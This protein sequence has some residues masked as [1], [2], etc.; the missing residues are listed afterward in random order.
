MTL[1]QRPFPQPYAILLFSFSA[2]FT[3]ALGLWLAQT[4]AAEYREAKEPT[5][6]SERLKVGLQP[7]G[8]IVVPTNQVL[9][10]A[11][12]QL[13]FAGRPVDCAL[14]DKGRTLIVKNIRELLFIDTAT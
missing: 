13:T 3:A 7:D 1:P 14:A 8:S 4:N 11:G 2:C 5:E 9:R 10:P 6:A 12:T